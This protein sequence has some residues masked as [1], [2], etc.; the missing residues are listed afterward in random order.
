MA[1]IIREATE[2][3][4][5]AIQQIYEYHVLNGTGTFEEVPPTL[6]DIKARYAKVTAHNYPYLVAEENGLFLGYAYGGFFRERSAYRFTVE[7]SI[8]ISDAARGKGVGRLLLQQL[9]VECKRRG[10]VQMFAIIGDSN[11]HASICLHE[12]CGFTI[13]GVMHQAGYKFNQWLD[14]VI[15]ELNLNQDKPI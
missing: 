1:I 4:L 12:K 2:A 9:I 13:T 7:D 15:M 8:Y 11:N 3:D 10:F 6:V 5:A 14:V